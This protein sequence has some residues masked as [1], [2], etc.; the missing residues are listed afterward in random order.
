MGVEKDAT[1]EECSVEVPRRGLV[2]VYTDG[3]REAINPQ[4]EIYGLARLCQRLQEAS[5]DP[6]QIG[7]GIV[8]D[9][10]QFTANNP[11]A[12]DM[13]LVCFQRE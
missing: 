4:R 9:V 7:Q 3:I 5:G 11:Q 13:C 6:Q 1:Y 2:A 10:R 12:D 8:D